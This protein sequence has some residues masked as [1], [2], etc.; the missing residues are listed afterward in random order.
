MAFTKLAASEWTKNNQKI[1]LVDGNDG[2]LSLPE[3]FSYKII[4][5]YKDIMDDSLLVP[6]AADGMACFKGNKDNVILIRNHELG[7]FPKLGSMF[8]KKNPFG[9]NFPSYLR[10]NKEKF[11]DSKRNKTECFGCT[12]TIVYDIKKEQL[13]KQYLS[14]GG[15]LIN[16]SGGPT[17]WN[18]W[19]SSEETVK[20]VKDNLNKNHGYNFEV[21]ASENINLNK[22]I[23]LKD[24][25][26]FRH[27]AVA[28]DPVNKLV[29][30]TEDRGDGL[31]YRFIPKVM[32]DFSKGGKLQA[33]SLKDFRGTDCSNW[34]QKIFKV[35]QK[36]IV[37]WIDLDNVDSPNDD[38]CAIS[39]LTENRMISARLMRLVGEAL[40]RIVEA[41]DGGLR[42]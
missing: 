2:V 6:N 20:G 26:R 39:Q 29:Y 21:K 27:E 32:G 7:H 3:G 15:T 42:I 28:V 23:P 17:P 16:C 11:Y 40:S 14:L 37:K 41:R 13:V 1:K 12:T 30:Q 34:K 33:L 25:G 36:R 18:T 38:D 5:K 22:A 24:M 10:K 35:G 31:F 8:K 19:I 9:K 4:S